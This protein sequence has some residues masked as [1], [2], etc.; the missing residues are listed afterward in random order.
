MRILP[1]FHLTSKGLMPIN[2]LALPT[3]AR[4]TFISSR[5]AV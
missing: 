3:F 1:L 4:G 5:K 2:P